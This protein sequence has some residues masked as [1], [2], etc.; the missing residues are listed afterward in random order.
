MR[1]SENHREDEH[2]GSIFQGVIAKLKKI[3][4]TGKCSKNKTTAPRRS[5]ALTFTELYFSSPTDENKNSV[6]VLISGMKYLTG[7]TDGERGLFGL[8]GSNLS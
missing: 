1:S 2:E 4:Y 8:K 7:T 6:K 5:P 3:K